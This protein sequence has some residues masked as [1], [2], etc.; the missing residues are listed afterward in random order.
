ML[1]YLRQYRRPNKKTLRAVIELNFSL[2]WS[3]YVG[4]ILLIIKGDF[5]SV[6]M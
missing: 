1:E 3:G 6:L 2:F 5:F 4:I